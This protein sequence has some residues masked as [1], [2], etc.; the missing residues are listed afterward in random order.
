MFP[1]TWLAPMTSSLGDDVSLSDGVVT[2]STAVTNLEF[3]DI[4]LVNDTVSGTATP[5]TRLNVWACD[6]LWLP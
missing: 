3:T 1:I 4:D 2:K 5:S 6:L